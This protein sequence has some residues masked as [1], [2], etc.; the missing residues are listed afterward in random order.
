[1]VT[2]A[3]PD[4]GGV[5]RWTS[6]TGGVVTVGVVPRLQ[7][8]EVLRAQGRTTGKERGA[9]A[10]RAKRARQMCEE[11][12][13]EARVQ[14]RAVR[15]RI[16]AEAGTQGSAEDEATQEVAAMATRHGSAPAEE[17]SDNKKKRKYASRTL[18]SDVRRKDAT[19]M[20]RTARRR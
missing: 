10:P 20:K 6:E 12:S 13:D 19:A 11:G 4:G 2:C 18:R 16:E 17:E 15:Q 9:A 14:A 8:Q 5:A 3:D 1:M 7:S